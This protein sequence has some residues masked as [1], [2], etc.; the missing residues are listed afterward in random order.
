MSVRRTPPNTMQNAIERCGFDPMLANSPNVLCEEEITP[1]NYTMLRGK[2]PREIDISPTQ[3]TNFKEEI[4]D[5]ISSL[6]T[7]QKRDFLGFND[8]LKEIRHTNI[9]IEK[10]IALLT[11]QNEEFRKKIEQL[12]SQTKKD[13]EY[14]S[15]LENKIEDLQR[16]T[17]KSCVEI[18]NVPKRP[19]ENRSDLIGMVMNLSKNINLNMEERDINDIFR[20]KAKKDIEKNPTII[21]E[22]GSTILKND[23]LKKIKDYNIK[24]KCRLRAKHLGFTIKEDTPVFISEQLTAKGA[25][26]FFLSRDLVRNKKY[27]YCWTSFGKVFVR[28]DETSKIIAIHEEEQIRNLQMGK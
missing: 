26:L 10:N 7:E 8:N 24:N 27:K 3:F 4:K 5:L 9:N 18:K 11:S 14:I 6:I 15:T 28:K 2:R 13:R 19:Q 17:R 12:E 20:L 21:V 22:L 25:R 16:C 1:P 23:L